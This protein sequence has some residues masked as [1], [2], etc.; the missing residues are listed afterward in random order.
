MSSFA[1]FAVEYRAKQQQ[2]ADTTTTIA[3]ADTLRGAAAAWAHLSEAEKQVCIE[4]S[5]HTGGHLS[6]ML[7]AKAYAPSREA[8]EEYRVSLKNWRDS[9]SVEAKRALKLRRRREKGTGHSLYKSFNFS[10]CLSDY[11][12]YRFISETFKEAVGDNFVE[13]VK[14]CARVWKELSSEAKAVS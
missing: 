13:K 8:I 7:S 9:L 14:D 6:K 2:D 5:Y 1:A 11:C 10:V 3:L 12:S 4:L